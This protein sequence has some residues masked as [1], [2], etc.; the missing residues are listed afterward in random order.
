M[1]FDFTLNALRKLYTSL[2][3]SDYDIIPFIRY[4]QSEDLSRVVIM[5]HDVD[6]N[7]KK[8]LKVAMMESSLGIKSTFYFRWNSAYLKSGTRDIIKKIAAMDHEIGYHYEVLSRTRGDWDRGIEL[9]ERELSEFR[10]IAD[11]RTVS[12]HGSPMS[13]HNSLDLWKTNDYRQYG[14]VGEPYFDI[15]YNSVLYLTDTGRMW[16]GE[17]YNV[18]DKAMGPGPVAKK[19]QHPL[20]STFDIIRAVERRELPDKIMINIH[21]QRW[22]DKWFPWFWELVSQTI[23]NVVKKRYVDRSSK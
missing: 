3:R 5:R 6:K 9:F 22:N 16:N 17:K 10:K 20:H 8:S 15:D 21:P 13:K 4:L 1:D 14:I 2:M 7:A 18:R 23:K 19:T 12:M 11:I